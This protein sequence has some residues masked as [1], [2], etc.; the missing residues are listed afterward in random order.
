ME[1]E[2]EFQ[3]WTIQVSELAF[4]IASASYLLAVNKRFLQFEIRSETAA[5]NVRGITCKNLYGLS[6]DYS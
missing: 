5:D 1:H 6:K 4:V 2:L 3:I